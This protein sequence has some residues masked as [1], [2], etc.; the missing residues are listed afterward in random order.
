MRKSIIWVLILI[1][2]FISKISFCIDYETYTNQKWGFQILIPKGWVITKGE[3]VIKFAQ[4]KKDVSPQA[5]DFMNRLGLVVNIS[6]Y[7]YGAEVAVNPNLSISA[8]KINSTLPEGE[9]E[10]LD[11]AGLK[12][13]SLITDKSRKYS[14]KKVRLDGLLGVKSFYTYQKAGLPEIRVEV[15]VLVD[16]DKGEYF[17]FI[18]TSRSTGGYLDVLIKSM[19]SFRRVED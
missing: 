15:M 14:F 10:I 12:L 3:D 1:S 16:K 4:S 13:F 2:L 6:K 11:F 7:P 8:K 9:K 18:S 19:K 5:L 17:T